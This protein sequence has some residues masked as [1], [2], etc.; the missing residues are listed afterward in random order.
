M[1]SVQDLTH[2]GTVTVVCTNDFRSIFSM[3]DIGE[4][5]GMTGSWAGLTE[6]AV[7]VTAC[8]TRAMQAKLKIQKT[9]MARCTSRRPV[10]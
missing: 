1:A 4:C 2:E 5:N 7:A 6:W 3:D 9:K 8:D 10:S